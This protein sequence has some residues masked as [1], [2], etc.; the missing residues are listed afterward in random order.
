MPEHAVQALQHAV[1]I[2]IVAAT[3]A[4]LLVTL[5]LLTMV[6]ALLALGLGNH[7][8]WQRLGLT[9]AAIWT[10]GLL[11]LRLPGVDLRRIDLQWNEALAVTGL[12]FLL[13][14]VTMV[15]P[16]EIAGIGTLGALLEAVSAVTTT[17]L[18]V[19]R[20][21][22]SADPALLFLRG[23]MQWYGGSASRC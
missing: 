5:G 8:L 19:L 11:L 16:L 4:Q 12:A 1:R 21:L 22:E 13:A 9:T 18:T 14:G 10:V 3:L 6:P 7:Q 2:R 23:W 15:W 17:G 20:D